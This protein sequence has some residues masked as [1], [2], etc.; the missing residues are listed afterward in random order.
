MK[1]GAM[2]IADRSFG[3]GPFVVLLGG[4]VAVA[5][6]LVFA[7][8]AHSMI[9]IWQ[10]SNTFTH[11]YLVVPIVIGLLWQRRTE[12]ARTPANAYWPGLVLVAG[13]GVLWLL[14]SLAS[15]NVLE[16]LALVLLIQGA[17]LTVLGVRFTRAIAF[18]LLFLLFAVPFGDAFVPQLMEW[19]ADFT[20]T[21]LKLSGIP[22]YREGNAFVIPSGRWSVVEAC[23]GIRFLIASLM[24]GTLFA[25]LTYASTSRRVA[26]IVASLIVPIVANWLRAYLIVLIGHLSSNELA[27]GVD[28]LIYGWIFFG[29]VLATMFW[30]GARFREVESGVS[31]SN[32]VR[33]ATIAPTQR[34]GLTAAAA[35]SVVV[36]MIWPPLAA[37]LAADMDRPVHAPVRIEGAN[38]WREV[39]A[40]A[41]RW[42]PQYSGYRGMLHQAFEREG[43]RI[44]VHVAF[45]ANQ[46]RD[47]ELV[48]SRNAIVRSDDV[49]WREVAR[50]STRLP[51]VG[52]PIDVRISTLS[53]PDGHVG[54]AA[55]YWIDGRTTSSDMIAKARLAL[56]RL[57]LRA[58]DSAAVFLATAPSERGDAAAALRAFGAD[59][60]GQIE[61]ALIA[62]HDGGRR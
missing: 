11:G 55:W 7:P 58:D 57:M 24:A 31:G 51:W 22:V 36:A 25:Y 38:G 54:V 56:A 37:A 33:G 61:R 48:N 35:A 30:V 19:T 49:N 20:V 4:V 2:A 40:V 18:P 15:V 3:E 9:A 1:S 8:T 46:T 50:G 12:L 16:H 44:S 32:V 10:G 28:H 59:M 26:F 27:A 43:V 52:E 41:V 13:A 17:L 21:A 34:R 23:S 42:Q 29:F 6:A 62:W 53:G 5:I 47:N 39:P 45:Y 60:G 14:G